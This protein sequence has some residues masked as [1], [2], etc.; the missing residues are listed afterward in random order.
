MT[1]DS[2]RAEAG[3]S[4]FF[5]SCNVAQLAQLTMKRVD[6]YIRAGLPTRVT[7]RPRPPAPTP[8]TSRS[9][10]TSRVSTRAQPVASFNLLCGMSP[11]ASCLP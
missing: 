6:C 1:V 4:G 5:Q 9:R 7:S 10:A 8:A 2:T 11:L 3:K